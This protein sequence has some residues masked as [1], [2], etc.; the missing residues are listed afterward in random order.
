MTPQSVMTPA[1]AERLRELL[2][3]FDQANG[4]KKDKE[5]DLANPPKVISSGG[6]QQN[7]QYRH[8]EYPLHMTKPLQGKPDLTKVARTAE[9]AE[10]LASKGYL[11]PADYRAHVASLAPEDQDEDDPE[12]DD[13]SDEE[14]AALAAD[15]SQEFDP[16]APAPK[17][18]G[19]KKK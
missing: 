18:R 4:G 10:K 3:Q 15:A 9:E 1:E 7:E 6:A 17:T 12:E 8:Q 11:N 2:G 19:R 13:L 5:F 16:N 14:V